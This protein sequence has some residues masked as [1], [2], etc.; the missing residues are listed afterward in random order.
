MQYANQYKIYSPRRLSFPFRGRIFLAQ[1]EEDIITVF[2]VK[3]Q[4]KIFKVDKKVE[5]KN[6]KVNKKVNK[7][8]YK[9]E[10]KNCNNNKILVNKQ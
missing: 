8:I 4:V 6:E 2:G 3:F 9:K 1:L 7:K 10:K 5:G